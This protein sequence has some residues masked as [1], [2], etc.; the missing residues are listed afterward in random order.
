MPLPTAFSRALRSMLRPQTAAA[1]ASGASSS[2]SS[3]PSSSSSSGSSSW[4]QALHLLAVT[5][6]LGVAPDA[7]SVA[8]ALAACLAEARHEELRRIL[9]GPGLVTPTLLARTLREVPD[10]QLAELRQAIPESMRRD[11]DVFL[12]LCVRD[13]SNPHRVI[14]AFEAYRSSRK[15]P[16]SDALPHVLRAM[17]SSRWVDAVKMLGYCRSQ[18]V[19]VGPDS[20]A[21]LARLSA[22]SSAWSFVLRLYSTTLQHVCSPN[23]PIV[24]DALI[25]AAFQRPKH[26]RRGVDMLEHAVE[27]GHEC[28]SYVARELFETAGRRGLWRTAVELFMRPEFDLRTSDNRVF[29]KM[30]IS[31]IRALRGAWRPHELHSV[32]EA[33][34]AEPDVRWTAD[35]LEDILTTYMHCMMP[36][37]AFDVYFELVR[38]DGTMNHHL[39]T[40]E[41]VGLCMA[42]GVHLRRVDEVHHMTRTMLLPVTTS[43][44]AAPLT[45][46]QKEERITAVCRAYCTY[47]PREWSKAMHTFESMLAAVDVALPVAARAHMVERGTQEQQGRAAAGW[48]GD[49]AA[50]LGRDLPPPHHNAQHHNQNFNIKTNNQNAYHRQNNR[51]TYQYS[52]QRQAHDH[53]FQ[54]QRQQHQQQPWSRGGRGRGG[55]RGGGYPP[56]PPHHQR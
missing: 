27:A 19:Y 17:P 38:S 4:D 32:V 1:A 28:E 49:V 22:G 42:A 6:T 5:R 10:D 39:W 24:T 14:E 47:L 33:L 52:D 13:T 18:G 46:A 41:V 9:D 56:R 8:E 15:K 2:T 26:A 36:S 40:P 3:S 20:Y 37:E 21:L 54:Q 12:S 45:S 51:S 35:M 11:P 30:C 7:E 29:Q 48:Q 34:L 43:S 25:V 55:G 23:D 53:F 16:P 50:T 44:A 31:L